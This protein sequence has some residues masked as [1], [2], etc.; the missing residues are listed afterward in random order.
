MKGCGRIAR[1]EHSRESRY[2]ALSTHKTIIA[3][4]D[5]WGYIPIMKAVITGDIINSR[6]GAIGG[7]LGDLKNVLATYGKTPQTWEIYRG[8]SFQLLLDNPSESL[9]A[10][11]NLK[12]SMKVVK[13]RDVRMAIGIGTVSY[14]TERVTES[15]GDV[16]IRSGERFEQLRTD[17]LT[18]AVSS[19]WPEWDEE[20]N[21]YIELALIA[22]DAWT[23][24]SAEY[25]RMQLT[26][27][28]LNQEEAAIRLGISQSSVSTR[29]KRSHFD[30]LAHLERRFQQTLATPPVPGR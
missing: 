5:S 25:V 8:D 15:N 12:A 29:K 6:R 22:M 27:N 19:P 9:R 4:I 11:M 17:R 21:L 2:R 7:T 18:L 20:I 23:V 24:A 14:R 3:I 16:F 28:G 26:E 10:A 30:T 13:S 1:H